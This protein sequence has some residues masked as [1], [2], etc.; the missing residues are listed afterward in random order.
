[1]FLLHRLAGAW[2][3]W[4]SK[5]PSTICLLLLP[6]LESHRWTT[7]SPWAVSCKATRLMGALHNL[8]PTPAYDVDL[9]ILNSHGLTLPA[10][11]FSSTFLQTSMVRWRRISTFNCNC[12]SPRRE[13]KSKLWKFLWPTGCLFPSTSTDQISVQTGA[14]SPLPA[15]L[16]EEVCLCL[17]QKFLVNSF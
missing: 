11:A 15:L 1:M 10:F 5:Q 6:L 9:A 8:P 12:S 7:T 14:R 13:R 2:S 3:R 4:F 17:W 16:P